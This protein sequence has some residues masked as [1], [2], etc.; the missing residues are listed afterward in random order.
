MELGRCRGE[1]EAGEGLEELLM[2]PVCLDVAKPPL[3]VKTVS[4]HSTQC[5]FTVPTLRCG[6]VP[7]AT[8]SVDPVLTA[9]SSWCCTAVP[10]HHDQPHVPGVPPVPCLPVRGPLQEQVTDYRCLTDNSRNRALEDLA[11]RTFPREAEAAARY[12]SGYI[13]PK[14]HIALAKLKWIPEVFAHS[15]KI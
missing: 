6:S 2:C 13:Y 14:V 1:G 11:R 3:Q 5:G 12:T 9:R 4:F 10:L 7:R 8:S 15:S